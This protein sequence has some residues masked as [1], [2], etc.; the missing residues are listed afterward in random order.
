M[1]I[2]PVRPVLPPAPKETNEETPQYLSDSDSALLTLV[3]ET[4]DALMILDRD[5]I[6]RFADRGAER[7]FGKNGDL[8]G[9]PTPIPVR[10]GDHVIETEDAGTLKFIEVRVAD[11]EWRGAPAYVAS[12]SDITARRKIEDAVDRANVVAERTSQENEAFFSGISHSLRTPLTDI[13]GF[14]ELIKEE[15]FGPLENDKYRDY[16]ADIHASS[17]QLLKMIDDVLGLSDGAMDRTAGHQN[18]TIDDILALAEKFKSADNTPRFKIDCPDDRTSLQLRGEREGLKQA[19]R[20]LLSDAAQNAIVDKPISLTLA[21]DNDQLSIEIKDCWLGH[22]DADI[23]NMID[24]KNALGPDPFALNP[25]KQRIQ[26]TAAA[27]GATKR[28]ADLTG[29]TFAILGND[30]NGVRLRIRLT[31]A[32]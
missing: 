19:F 25:T 2:S 22:T 8:V 26:K 16:I 14:S 31:I 12:A 32:P 5:G 10:P 6:V 28:M 4:T 1:S 21:T 27:F 11:S 7:L 3:Q 29:G 20:S 15:R 24:G 13:I 17:L 23:A 30:H 9:Q 18:I